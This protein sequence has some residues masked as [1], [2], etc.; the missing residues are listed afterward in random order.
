MLAITVGNQI[1]TTK[2]S[3]NSLEINQS[4]KY[5]VSF[6]GAGAEGTTDAKHSHTWEVRDEHA[7]RSAVRSLL[8]GVS[9]RPASA[10]GSLS[11]AAGLQ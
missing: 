6:P 8:V 1:S 2:T 3:G 7:A 10:R 4:I 5:G 9:Y 11:G